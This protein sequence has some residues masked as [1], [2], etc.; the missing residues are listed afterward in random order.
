MQ[1]KTIPVGILEANCYL[2]IKDNKCIIIDP[3]AYK[4]KIIEAIGDLKPVFI[5]TTHNHFD[6]VGALDY[7]KKYYNI[8]HYDM[9][10]LEEKE[11][12][13][14]GFKFEIIYTKG[15]SDTSLTIYFKEEK[16]MFTG[17]FLFKGSIGRTDLET[18]DDVEMNKSL[19]KIKQYP[20]DI[21][22]YP[23]HGESSNLKYEKE[24][25]MFL[26]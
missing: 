1:I 7:I 17:D 16:M 6:H 4:K 12:D 18:G 11:Y 10:N 15:H 13:I 22:I 8:K 26:M 25:N 2:I 24:N 19:N 21:T 5:I 3:G 23:G 9:S 20:N 14:D